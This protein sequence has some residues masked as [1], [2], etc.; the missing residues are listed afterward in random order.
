MQKLCHQGLERCRDLEMWWLLAHLPLTLI[1]PLQKTDGSW[2]MTADY[3]KLNQMVTQITAAVPDV[4]S[5]LEQMNTSP[6]P[7]E[8]ICISVR[9][10]NCIALQVYL[11]YIVTL[12]TCV[13]TVFE[14]VLFI[15]LFHKIPHWFTIL[16][17][18][19][20]TEWARENKHFG[21]V[22]DIYAHQ[23]VGNKFNQNSRTYF[24]EISVK[25][26]GVQWCGACRD[27]PSM[28]RDELLH[29][30]PPIAKTEAQCLVGL[31]GFW[32]QHILHFSMLFRSYN[33][34]LGKLLGLIGAWFKRRLLFH[35]D[36][37]I[38]QTR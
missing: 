32:R 9:K 13:R 34:W 27:I 24:S 35:M 37:M 20:W 38:Q 6:R 21:L 17:T 31:F 12:Q 2:K 26:L 5:L 10:P 1:W 36:H 7:P 14:V 11:E 8:A 16:M 30:A 28:V 4:V 19:C 15:C 22:G 18:W 3:W 33:E 25:F 29:L 23:R